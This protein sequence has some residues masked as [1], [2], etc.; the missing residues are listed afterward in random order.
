MSGELR[1]EIIPVT[2]FEQNCS[3]LWDTATG[4][5]ALVDAGGEVDHL[6][7]RARH[8]GVTLEKLLVTH[9]HLDHAS[10]VR[11][12]AERLGLPIEGPH[13]DDQFWIDALPEHA[14]RYGFPPARSF[15]PDRWLEH[16]ESVGVGSL[17]F[18]VLRDR[19]TLYRERADGSIE[20]VY[21]LK[22]TND[23]ERPHRYAVSASLAD[24]TPLTVEPAELSRAAEETGAT[25]VTLR[26]R[27]QGAGGVPLAAVV[28]IVLRIS[29]ADEPGP[30]RER[31][32]RFLTGGQP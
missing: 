27:P 4:R 6:L 12:L 21:T 32:A 31:N 14:R 22:V 15:T 5:G 29:Q 19:H 13:R 30:I 17:R 10:G 7:E 11:D 20:N 23:D 16:G 26:T 18:D 28:P 9:G 8:H 1:V 25:T 2:A 24:G 3:L